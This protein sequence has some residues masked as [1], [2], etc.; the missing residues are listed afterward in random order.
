M[1]KWRL[2]PLLDAVQV[3]IGP[4][5]DHTID[6]CRRCERPAV[7]LIGRQLPELLARLD[8][9]GQP[10]LVEKVDAA[11]G[12]D[13]RSREVAAEPLLPQLLA[14]FRF[15]QVAMPLSLTRYKC[16]PTRIGE[17]FAARPFLSD[18]AT[19]VSVTSPLPPSFT[20]IRPGVSY[21]VQRKMRPCPTQGAAPPNSHR[22]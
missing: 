10:F 20:A 1:P 17:G 11:I 9:G 3:V 4:Q 14:R 18:Q 6:K 15:T 13:G 7:D 12:V 22:I 19:C 5:K 8:D 21:P 2:A 16:E